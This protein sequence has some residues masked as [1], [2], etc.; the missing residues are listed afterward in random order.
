MLDSPAEFEALRKCSFH[1]VD[2]MF[3][4]RL[5]IHCCRFL[6]MYSSTVNIYEKT[7]TFSVNTR[8]EGLRLY[9]EYA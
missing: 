6:L 5:T 3:S 7:S 2:S 1:F 9:I 8:K 4:S